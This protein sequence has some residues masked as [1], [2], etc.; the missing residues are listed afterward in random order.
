MLGSLANQ[1]RLPD[2]VI[3]LDEAGEAKRLANNYP[4]LKT[5][6][7]SFPRGSASAKR[8]RGMKLVAPEITLVG[9]M[10]DDIVLEPKALELMLNFWREASPEVGGVS[11][12]LANHPPIFA[13]RL[14]SLGMTSKLALYD[15][16]PGLVLRSGIHTLIG[17]V[18]ENTSAQW[19]PTTAVVYRRQ[20]LYEQAFDEWYQGYSYL[21]DLDLSYSVGKKYKLAVL[22]GARFY[23]YPSLIGRTH[24]YSF[25][26]MEV[27]NRLHFVR[28]HPELSPVRCYLALTIRIFISI[29]LGFREMD[30]SFFKRA[31]GNIA[32]FVSVAT[33]RKQPGA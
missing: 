4:Q 29:Y 1:T 20:V 13:L 6:V 26:K 24:W 15:S 2:Q 9:L 19:L 10:D 28:K 30:G 17:F 31:C 18:P 21:E 11:F 5:L 22:A 3:I 32:G 33:P 8:N 23:H 12:N 25:G 7:T 16:R 27:A 14:K